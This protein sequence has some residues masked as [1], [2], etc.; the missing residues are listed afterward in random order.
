LA[1]RVTSARPKVIT[2]EADL[3]PPPLRKTD[4]GVLDM[5]RGMAALFVVLHH[6]R[7]YL[8]APYHDY[9]A[10][11]G[12]AIGGRIAFASTVLKFGPE[13]VI[14]FFLLSGFCI[15]YRQA[16]RL[17]S[18][19]DVGRGVGLH[20]VLDVKP[21]FMRRIRRLLPV[22]LVAIALTSLLDLLGLAINPDFYAATFLPEAS[23]SLSTLVGNALFQSGLAVPVYGTDVPLWSLALEFWFYVLYPLML[24][25]SLRLGLRGMLAVIGVTGLLGMMLFYVGPAPLRGVGE[26]CAYWLIWVAGALIAEAYVGRQSMRFAGWCVWPSLLLLV[27]LTAADA[28]DAV[29]PVVPLRDMAW[30]VA[31]GLGLI[32]VLLGARDRPQAVLHVLARRLRPLGTISY[33]LYV[34][35]YPIIVVLAAWWTAHHR[36][37]PVGVE[38]FV[39]GIGLSLSAGAACW[40]VVERHFVGARQAPALTPEIRVAELVAR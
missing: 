11:G 35:H 3:A 12:S 1:R 10:L 17:R 2:A 36:T 22:L 16:R 33:S 18:A 21:F 5:L 7:W 6:A 24:W 4:L 39:L 32:W 29:P 14:F 19:S 25:V 28:Q 34:V 13:A 30:A 26:V 15:H 27:G 23:H 20:D 9:A 40:Y 31:L 37:A 38:L 8:L